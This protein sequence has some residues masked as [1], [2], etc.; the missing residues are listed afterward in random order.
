[1]MRLELATAEYIGARAQQQDLAAA[2]PLGAGAM[3]VLADGLGGHEGGAEA[4]RIVVETFKQAGANGLFN[5]VATRRQALRDT[6]ERA[7]ARI[8]EGA[9]PADG[10]RGM[11]S[12]VVA[13][14]VSN[15]DLS[16]VSVGDSH[17]Y[18]WRGGRLSKLNEDHSQAGLMVRSGKYQ[19]GDPEVMAVRSVLV[20]ALTGRKLEIVDLPQT[21][22]RLQAGDVLMLA[23]DG[24]NTLPDTE[25]EG[26]VGEFRAQGSIKL[27]TALLERVRSR[28]VE[29]QDNTTVAVARVLEPVRQDSVEAPRRATG[30][31]GKALDPVNRKSP[32]GAPFI[33]EHALEIRTERI[34]SEPAGQPDQITTEP[35]TMPVPRPVAAAIEAAAASTPAAAIDPPP[36]E[37]LDGEGPAKAAVAQSPVSGTAGETPDETLAGQEVSVAQGDAAAKKA[38]PNSSPRAE[39]NGRVATL[40]GRPATKSNG[41][42][43]V[44]RGWREV[45]EDAVPPVLP[46]PL[47]GGPAARHSGFS[48]NKLI[49]VL[50]GLLLLWLIAG[51]VAIAAI[52]TLRPEWLSGLV[53]GFSSTEVKSTPTSQEPKAKTGAPEPIVVPVPVP[54]VRP[55]SNDATGASDAAPAPRI[56][57]AR[58]PDAD[59]PPAAPATSPAVPGPATG[60]EGA[61]SGSAAGNSP[62]TSPASAPPPA[63]APSTTA[64]PP[65][66]EPERPAARPGRAP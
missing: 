65:L 41:A 24:L 21:T 62:A 10:H 33:D 66:V 38:L 40:D 30:E 43:I 29:R 58:R 12:T 17:L 46:S 28:R 8:A 59:Q 18:V 49:R 15:G 34:T 56:E 44:P 9:N 60:S 11:A 14:I 42:R 22:F 51:S 39:S 6:L 52:A 23:S 27:S 64:D 4:A 47:D 19:P 20:S 2:M 53:P 7:N 16:W 26:M 63:A 37:A 31:A 48:A 54:A 36:E 35:A 57:P 45:E 61:S 3:L 1:M 32:S 55:P 13:A 25:I 50:A 5:A